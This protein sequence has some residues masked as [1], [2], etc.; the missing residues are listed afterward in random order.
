M[1]LQP[2]IQRAVED[3]FERA[4]QPFSSIVCQ[5]CHNFVN[6]SCRFRRLIRASSRTISPSLRRVHM[7]SPAPH[8]RQACAIPPLHNGDVFV[9]FHSRKTSIGAYVHR[10][11]VDVC[12]LRFRTKAD[13][14]QMRSST[15]ALSAASLHT[16]AFHC[17][18]HEADL[19]RSSHK[20]VVAKSS[21]VIA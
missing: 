12:V 8:H 18:P 10:A 6:R 11:D 5:S 17:A 21:Q 4:Q 3:K 13:C 7:I 1:P 14:P 2:P 16:P 15:C 9:H 19:L 20:A